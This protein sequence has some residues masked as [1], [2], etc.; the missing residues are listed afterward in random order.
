[1]RIAH[2]RAVRAELRE[3]LREAA[4]RHVAYEERTDEDVAKIAG[5]VHH[6]GV[7][8][9]VRPRVVGTTEALIERMTRGPWRS[10][11]A[12]DDV[13]NPHN[14]GAITRTAAFFGVDALLVAPPADRAPL[15]PAAVRVAQGGAEEIA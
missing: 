3:V 12:L 7:C 13:S 14:V 5:S 6:E 15:A 1:M 2:T 11:V 4:A 8:F 10:A 9:A